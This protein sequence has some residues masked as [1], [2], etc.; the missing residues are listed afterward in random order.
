MGVGASRV[1]DLFDQGRK[2][3]KVDGK[4]RVSKGGGGLHESEVS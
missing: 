2:A 3:G 1:R 4:G